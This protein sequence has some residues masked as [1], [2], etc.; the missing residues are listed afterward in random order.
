V[1]KKKDKKCHK[2]RFMR[3][4]AVL[5]LIVPYCV[6]EA[7]KEQTL[8]ILPLYPTSM[9]GK[10]EQHWEGCAYIQPT[11]DLPATSAIS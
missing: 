5:L 7:G 1:L 2:R 3:S 11:Q 9:A 6:W 8:G 4:K 10:E